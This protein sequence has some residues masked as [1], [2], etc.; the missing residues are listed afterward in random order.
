MYAKF[1][2]TLTIM[3]F[4]APVWSCAAQALLRSYGAASGHVGAV[5]KELIFSRQATGRARKKTPPGVNLLLLSFFLGLRPWRKGGSG[6]PLPLIHV[7]RH[8]LN[9]DPTS[10]RQRC[11]RTKSA[12][13]LEPHDRPV[14]R[15]APGAC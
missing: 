3:S 2:G 1:V 10:V 12:V 7:A 9:Y 6:P 11:P 8:E 14:P 4:H 13:S 5:D 15:A